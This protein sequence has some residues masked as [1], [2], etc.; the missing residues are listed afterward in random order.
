[1][2]RNN[3]H[4]DLFGLNPSARFATPLIVK[5]AGNA[6]GYF[7]KLTEEWDKFH[8]I[9]FKGGNINAIFNPEVAVEPL[10]PE[11][12]LSADGVHTI[13]SRPWSDYTRTVDVEI[14]GE[15]ATLTLSVSHAGAKHDA[16]HM[17]AY[18][19][20]ELNSFIRFSFEKDQGLDKIE[21]YYRIVRSLVAVLTMQNNVTFELYLS[22][23]NSEGQFIKSAI[24]KVFDHYENY[25]AKQWHRVIPICRIFN[26]LPNFLEKIE[27]N[28]VSALLAVLPDDNRTA[29][30]ISITNVQ[31]MCTALEVAYSWSKRH[32]Q[33][34]ALIEELKKTI[35]STIDEFMKTHGEID[36]HKET[37]I[38]SAFRYLDFTLVQRIY[39]LYQE[40]SE[41]ID[42]ITAKH[43]LPRLD[44][45]NI[46]AF[47]KLRNKRTHRGTADWGDNA[48]IYDPLFALLYA[49][50]L[51][52]IGLPD[53]IVK[54]ICQNIF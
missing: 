3:F 27:C 14:Y 4:T 54:A 36:V 11:E 42:S 43:S 45:D 21:R 37:T 31:D 25:S 35:G 51:T 15:K 17:G 5:A 10:N 49:C 30:L 28:G 12:L 20:G 40:N 44:L 18:S 50:F 53:D 47:V 38:L 2:C 32:K 29:N 22:Q 7:D 34:D 6:S 16:A 39:T 23:R 48:Q 41:F 26:C 8:A 24:C 1:M 33:K 13:K 46:S 19:L 52:S 9:T